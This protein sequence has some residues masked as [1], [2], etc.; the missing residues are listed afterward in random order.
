MKSRLTITDL[1]SPFLGADQFSAASL[2]STVPNTS[3]VVRYSIDFRTVH[4][5]DVL[6]RIGAANVDSE[7]TGTTMDD[8]LRAT[9]LSHLPEEAIAMYHDGSE[10]KYAR[11]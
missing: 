9:D 10:V 7:C 4:L 6:D 5:A 11:V 2:H 3:D 8:Y 1:Q